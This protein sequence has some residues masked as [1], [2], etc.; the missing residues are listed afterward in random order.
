MDS[1]SSTLVRKVSY[2]SLLLRALSLTML[3]KQ[4]LSKAQVVASVLAVMVAAL[5]AFY[6]RHNSPKASPGCYVFSYFSCSWSGNFF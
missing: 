2:C 4:G 1:S 6:R 3:L 5:G